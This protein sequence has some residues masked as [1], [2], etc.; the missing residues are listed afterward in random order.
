LALLALTSAQGKT[1]LTKSHQG[2]ATTQEIRGIWSLEN[3]E[4]SAGSYVWSP[5]GIFFVAGKANS[6]DL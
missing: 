6:R 3:Q 5:D 4:D 2:F 1:P